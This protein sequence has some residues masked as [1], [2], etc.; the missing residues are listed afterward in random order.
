MASSIRAEP[1]LLP[2]VSPPAKRKK[3]E[4]NLPSF[5][6]LPNKAQRQK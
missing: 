4:L 1:P 3:R 5:N 6:K 2:V